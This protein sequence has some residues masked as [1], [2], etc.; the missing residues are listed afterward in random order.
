MIRRS[1]S[2]YY[3]KFLLAHP[4]QYD[5]AH[6]KRICEL[7][8]L[9]YL[10]EWYLQQ[11]RSQL[12]LPKPFHPTDQL[13][14]TSQ[15][16]IRKEM[17]QRAFLPNDAMKIALSILEKATTRELVEVMILSGAPHQAIVFGLNARLHF[18]ATVEAIDL[19]R[20]YFWDVDLLDTTELRA[21]LEMRLERVMAHDDPKMR[22][23]YSHLWRQR[24]NDPRIVASKL[25]VSPLA[26][27]MAQIQLGVMPRDLNVSD[28]LTSIRLMAS[29]RALE[30]TMTGGPAGSQMASNFM[31]T[32]DIANR[33][34]D[35]ILKPEDQLRGELNKIALRTTAMKTPLLG[36]LS[37]G[38]HTTQLQPAPEPETEEEKEDVKSAG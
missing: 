6:V 26:A 24:H 18:V 36:A 31:M 3:I 11:L 30:A 10:G 7:H 35:T 29:L 33:L 21:F 38:N 8:N 13:H 27:M 5:E 4:D 20:H 34:Y 17:I 19:Y 14:L 22:A 32:A 15:R 12:Q 25:P 16:F 9:E 2:E 28:V 1:P 37:G 23:Q